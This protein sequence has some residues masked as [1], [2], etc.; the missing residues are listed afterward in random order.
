MGET[1]GFGTLAAYRGVMKPHVSPHAKA[2][3]KAFIGPNNNC[4]GTHVHAMVLMVNERQPKGM[5]IPK[6]WSDLMKP[7][8]KGKQVITVPAR[9]G[10]AFS[11]V[12][13]LLKQYGHNGLE[14]IA[15]NAVVVQSSGQVC[16]SVAVGEYPVGITI[17]SSAYEFVA[18][19]QKEIKLVCPSEGTSLG[20]EG[21]F[22]IKCAKNMALAKQFYDMRLSTQAQE[23][24]LRENVRRPTRSDIAVARRTTMPGLAPL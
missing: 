8:W 17:E 11:Q 3:A 24:L 6:T 20:P 21:M 12:C 23:T 7:E 9:S 4:V 16:K 14:R 2:I 13:G 19:G 22:I 15:R 5:A 1:G 18:S 10:T